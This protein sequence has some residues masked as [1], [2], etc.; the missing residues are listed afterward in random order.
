MAS[1]KLVSKGPLIL[2][3]NTKLFNLISNP[4]TN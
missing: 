1:G 2:I 3:K 4:Q